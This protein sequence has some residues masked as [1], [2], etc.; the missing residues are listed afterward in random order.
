MSTA[1]K[2]VVIA[3]IA[4]VW[5]P[6]PARAV[7]NGAAKAGAH[8]NWLKRTMRH[9]HRPQH[10]TGAVRGRHEKRPDAK[11]PE[12]ILHA[13]AD[14]VAMAEA[15]VVGGPSE[16]QQAR[17]DAHGIGEDKGNPQRPASRRQ[18]ATDTAWPSAIGRSDTNTMLRLCR[19]RPSATANSQPMAGFRP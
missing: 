11:T 17:A 10:E 7:G 12:P 1:T 8:L 15:P 18:A 13:E 9:Q 3:S 14:A 16:Q 6:T 2:A 4:M 5:S 19:C